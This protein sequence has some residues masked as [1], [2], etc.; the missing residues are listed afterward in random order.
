ML[1]TIIFLVTLLFCVGFVGFFIV[2]FGIYVS[3]EERIQWIRK[4]KNV[5]QK[6]KNSEIIEEDDVV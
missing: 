6:R 4:F 2:T 3:M 5:V 1:D